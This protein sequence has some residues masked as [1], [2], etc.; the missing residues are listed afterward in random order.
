MRWTPRIVWAAISSLAQTDGQTRSLSG[1][2]SDLKYYM[3]PTP[4]GLRH[5]TRLERREWL[6]SHD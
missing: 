1:L 2:R 3:T 6:E 5:L 4:T